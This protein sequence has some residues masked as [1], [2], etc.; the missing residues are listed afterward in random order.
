[1]RKT[2]SGFTLIE[3]MIT[4]AIVGI[5]AG[6]AYPAYMSQVLKSGRADA[7]VAL[8]DVAQR[9]Q[10]CFTANSTYKPTAGTCAVVDGA[11]SAAGILSTEKF[12]VV[13]LVSGTA[14]T[15]TAY[16][17]IATPATGSRQAKDNDCISFTI[18]QIGV[19]SAKK[20]GNVDN[21]AACW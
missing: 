19:R 2:V 4:V 21:T 13:K 6:I 11:T 1:M 7:K 18:N 15:A 5:L 17:L 8:S 10:R 12:Y 3:L 9:M 20:T 14:H 16:E